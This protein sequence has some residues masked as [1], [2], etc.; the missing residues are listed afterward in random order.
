VRACSRAYGGSGAGNAIGAM[1]QVN[2][3]IIPGEAIGDIAFN[4]APGIGGHLVRRKR[5]D[6]QSAFASG[7]EVKIFCW[8]EAGIATGESIRHSG[9][10]KISTSV[11]EE[12]TTLL[13]FEGFAD[14][15]DSIDFIDRIIVKN[16]TPGRTFIRYRDDTRS[17]RRDMKVVRTIGDRTE[18]LACYEGLDIDDANDRDLLD[19]LEPGRSASWRASG[20]RLAH[21]FGLSPISAPAS[22]V[23]GMDAALAA[24]EIVPLLG[25][26]RAL[27]I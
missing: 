6:P 16:R 27:S 12:P 22:R 19:T 3:S 5:S 8:I 10:P 24:F 7:T 9:K 21:R 25:A 2:A 11:R 13:T 26:P 23:P 18:V 20:G 15:A 17:G 4:R 1:L 14:S